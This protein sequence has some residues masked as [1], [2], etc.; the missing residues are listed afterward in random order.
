MSV[1]A[2][3]AKVAPCDD[4][5]RDTVVKEKTETCA[6]TVLPERTLRRSGDWK[7]MP[8]TVMLPPEGDRMFGVTERII[9]ETTANWQRL[10]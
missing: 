2:G 5:L 7:S 1:M 6:R 3:M 8:T 10:P 9:G 4:R